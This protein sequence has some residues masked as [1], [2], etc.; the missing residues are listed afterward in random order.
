MDALHIGSIVHYCYNLGFGG[1][2]KCVAAIVTDVFDKNTG[3]INVRE[4]QSMDLKSCLYS[5][6]KES[7]GTWHWAEGCSS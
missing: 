5:E 2:P 3:N 4:F 7:G 1:P 6:A